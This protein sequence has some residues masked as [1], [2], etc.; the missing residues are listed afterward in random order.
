MWFFLKTEAFPKPFPK[1]TGFWEWLNTA[2]DL[3]VKFSTPRRDSSFSGKE[4]RYKKNESFLSNYG[5]FYGGSFPFLRRR[6]AGTAP[7]SGHT[8]IDNG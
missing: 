2:S 7:R 1:L 8:G 4:F 6:A 3:R 5:G